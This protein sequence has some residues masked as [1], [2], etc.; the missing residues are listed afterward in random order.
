MKA[1][2]LNLGLLLSS[3]IGFLKW[4]NNSEFLYEME[5]DIIKKSMTDPLSIIHPLI[6]LPFAGQLI[7]LL[8]LFISRP[9]KWLTYTGIG[10]LALLFLTVLLVGALTGTP[11]QILSTL[12]FLGLSVWVILN[13]RRKRP[14]DN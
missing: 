12:P 3:F 11:S 6:I 8:T 2:L 4:G 1:K 7:L 5:W 9:R 14:L 10:L 13:S